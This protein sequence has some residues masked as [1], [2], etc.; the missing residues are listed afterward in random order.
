MSQTATQRPY[1]ATFILD[2]RNYQ[3]PVETLIEKIKETVTTVEG[4]VD[5]VEN[6]GQKDFIR[7]T[8]RNR[9]NGIY[10]QVD[11]SGPGSAPAALKEKFRLD[12]TIDRILIQ[13]KD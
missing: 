12:K 2:L 11:F 3:E 13:A 7:V 5:S 4:T 10:V 8:D 6:L 1:R 9:P